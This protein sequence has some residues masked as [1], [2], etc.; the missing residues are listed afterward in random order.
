MK[1]KFILCLFG[2]ISLCLFF[3]GCSTEN[4]PS[5]FKREVLFNNDWK[6]I[7]D[8]ITGAEQLKFDDSK[9]Q[10][11][12]LPHDYSIMPLEGED[13]ESQIGPFTKES[14]G[15]GNSVGHVL[16]GTGWY[17]K[18]FVLDRADS[19]KTAVLKFDGVYMESDVWVNGKKV[20]VH[21]NGY[22]PFWFDI[23]DF[24]N[25]PGE[26]N[27]IAV[28]VD[29]KGRNSRWYS[30]SG[31]YR[32]VHLLLT[33]PL[34]VGVWGTY[35]TTSKIEE[36]SALID[37]E[38]NLQNNGSEN[39]NTGLTINIQ[40]KNGNIVGTADQEISIN[41]DS[42][43]I[44]KSQ[45]EIDTPSL[46][47]LESPNLYTAQIVL[48][49]DDE[50]VDVYDQRF[51]IRTIE[52]S[53]EKGFVLNGKT[54]LL[55]G[56]GMHHD[57]GLLGAAAF[58]RAE[59]RKVEIMKA[60]GFNAIRSAHNPPSKAFLEACDELG[61]LVIDEFT[62]MWE[63]YKNPQDYSR[64]FDEWWNKDLTDFMLRDRNHPSIIMWSIGNEIN[65]KDRD[66]Y[67][68]IAKN[69]SDR[70]RELDDTR[71][72]SQALTGFFFPEWETTA[73]NFELMDV[74]GYNYLLEKVVPD[75]E[76]Y[77]DRVMYL[78]ESY[79]K[80]AYEYWEAVEK[81][82]YVIGDFVWTAWDYLGEVALGAPRYIPE[83][84]DSR[85]SG[86]FGGFKLEEGEN[87]FDV[88][89]RRPSRWPNY[90]ANCG[91]IDITGEKS[92]QMLYRDIIW[93]N[94]KI[95]MSVHE[96]VPEGYIERGSSWAWPV[97]WPRWNWKGHEGTSLQVRVFT[98][99]PLVKLELNGTLIDERELS[100]SDKYIAVFD[101]PYQPG[102]L[103]ATAYLDNSEYGSKTLITSGKAAS[104]RL[105]TDRNVLN[106]DRNDLS[107]IKIEVVDKNGQVV[108]D[109][110][111]SINISVSGDGELIGSGNASK[112]D[113]E[114]FNKP[115]IKTFQGRAQAIVRP[116]EKSGTIKL[117]AKSVGLNTG[118]LEISV[119]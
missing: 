8:S 23:T 80:T 79:P 111:H 58:D 91:D 89:A 109:E 74:S 94:S 102:E 24:L 26:T 63:Y 49:K 100:Q 61:M 41:A 110:E 93:E 88:F 17:R 55:K 45:I 33:D 27:V 7:R 6:F 53:A 105:T 83:D 117:T 72:V 1:S 82:P 101:V 11:V 103:K 43:S 57:N 118:E 38:V 104:I 9:W 96:P 71:A 87:I 69:L 65:I 47:S 98:K 28:K 48:E 70:V 25:K 29:N 90:L 13:S 116:F 86:N 44:I 54:V 112:D 15:N 73:E 51:G 60:N 113:M 78:S 84:P 20:G 50:I 37:V 114:S 40:D 81:Y 36:K 14:P 16:G 12:D 106:P 42:N 5:E 99:A 2:S 115:K 68:R 64:F 75:H 34:H 22:T 92:P 30:G 67:L 35:I 18:S 59:R 4:N 95:E 85:G 97:E 108:T 119:K 19:D 3:V 21:K 46:W 32:N 76:Q 52:F 77:P 66:N 62:D 31:I 56:G 107:F 39:T 10:N